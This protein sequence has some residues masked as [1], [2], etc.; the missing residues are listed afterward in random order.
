[1]SRVRWLGPIS[2]A[3]LT[4]RYHALYAT[5]QREF[6]RSFIRVISAFLR[7]SRYVLCTVTPAFILRSFLCDKY[8]RATTTAANSSKME[9][10]F[11]AG[12]P[13]RRISNSRFPAL[14]A[15]RDPSRAFVTC[16]THSAITHYVYACG[17]SSPIGL[18]APLLYPRYFGNHLILYN[19][20]FI[21]FK[22]CLFWG[23]T[24]KGEINRLSIFIKTY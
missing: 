4:I 1:M 21:I 23:I 19:R 9:R 14:A 5:S 3:F 18:H 2:P 16:G 22:L 12:L 8:P 7:L 20:T 24:N 17:R 13:R 11:C 10:Y 6:R 15:T